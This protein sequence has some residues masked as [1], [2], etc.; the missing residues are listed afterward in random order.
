MQPR[1]TS[2]ETLQCNELG[3]FVIRGSAFVK[4]SRTF[5]DSILNARSD[6]T[7]HQL[8]YGIA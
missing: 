6:Q 7:Q 4:A 5:V 8:R 1:G 2:L 3:N